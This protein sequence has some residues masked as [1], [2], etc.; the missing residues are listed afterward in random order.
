[1]KKMGIL[2]IA[3]SFTAGI[4]SNTDAANEKRRVVLGVPRSSTKK[5]TKKE[6]LNHSKLSKIKNQIV[7]EKNN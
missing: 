5:K 6:Q 4:L 3:L 1:M 2:V 7:G